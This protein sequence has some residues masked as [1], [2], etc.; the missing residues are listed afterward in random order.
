MAC[1]IEA[2]L[3]TQLHE[4]IAE[5]TNNAQSRTSRAVSQYE[6]QLPW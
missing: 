6:F 4:A 3:L 1:C 5:C 2:V